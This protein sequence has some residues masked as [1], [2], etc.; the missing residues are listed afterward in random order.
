MN[1]SF[2]FIEDK[3]RTT[4]MTNFTTGVVLVITHTAFF[5]IGLQSG[6]LLLTL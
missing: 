6:L 2:D 4:T 5:L 3:E 1:D